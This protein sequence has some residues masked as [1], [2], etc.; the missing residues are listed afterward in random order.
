MLHWMTEGSCLSRDWPGTTQEPE[1]ELIWEDSERSRA[2]G[3]ETST[4]KFSWGYFPNYIRKKAAGSFLNIHPAWPLYCHCQKQLD[5]SM[6]MFFPMLFHSST[7]FTTPSEWSVKIIS[8]LFYHSDDMVKCPDFYL[9]GL[10][11]WWNWC[12]ALG[13]PSME[14]VM[15][16]LNKCH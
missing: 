6:G 8:D 2:Y 9:K 3:G 15:S 5:Y 7:F 16:G 1:D 11:Q 4:F 13:S 10:G 14:M 12:L